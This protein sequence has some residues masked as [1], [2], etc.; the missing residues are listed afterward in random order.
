MQRDKSVEKFSRN[1]NTIASTL[2]AKLSFHRFKIKSLEAKQSLHRFKKKIMF[3][4][5]EEKGN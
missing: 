3:G 4:E 5:K 2:K 1:T